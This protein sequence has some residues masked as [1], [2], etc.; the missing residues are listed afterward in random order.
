M[1]YVTTSLSLG[2][3]SNLSTS[4]SFLLISTFRS[5]GG[6]TAAG[7]GPA[8]NLFQ[9]ACIKNGRGHFN[10]DHPLTCCPLNLVLFLLE[11]REFFF[12]LL[13]LPWR[14]RGGALTFLPPRLQL[15]SIILGSVHVRAAQ[16]TKQVETTSLKQGKPR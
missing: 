10:Y 7:I 8:Q 16:M 11:H 14:R 5:G 13:L 12:L 1:S 4:M 15:W 2:T 3:S 9:M 6:G